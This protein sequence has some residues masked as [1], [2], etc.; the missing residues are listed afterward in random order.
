M[1]SSAS[2]A[3]MCVHEQAI[4]L[5]AIHNPYDKAIAGQTWPVS[6]LY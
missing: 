6:L 4:K 2:P 5:L 1:N 3:V